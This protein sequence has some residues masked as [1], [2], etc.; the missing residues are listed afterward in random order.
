MGNA[1][2][3]GNRPG[4]LGAGAGTRTRNLLFTRQPP[5]V[6]VVLPRSILAAQVGSVVRVVPFCCAGSAVVE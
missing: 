2:L 3:H 6:Y 5:T 1:L 4:I